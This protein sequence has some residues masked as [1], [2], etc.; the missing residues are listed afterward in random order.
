MINKLDILAFSGLH[1]SPS[2]LSGWW[3]QSGPHSSHAVAA[4]AAALFRPRSSPPQGQCSA[5]S[6]GAGGGKC[7]FWWSVPYVCMD[8]LGQ[9]YEAAHISCFLLICGAGAGIEGTWVNFL[10]VIERHVKISCSH[11]EFSPFFLIILVV[12]LC[13][14]WY[15]VVSGIRN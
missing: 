4:L 5:L 3:E 2:H 7:V 6:V 14:F 12:M 9:V 11:H 13:T 8:L 10:P 1:R 15:S